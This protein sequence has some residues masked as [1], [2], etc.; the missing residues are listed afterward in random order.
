[1][2]PD[3]TW[4]SDVES[5]MR[6][7]VVLRGDLWRSARPAPVVIFRTPYGR[8]KISSDVLKPM[9][10][11]EFGFAAFVQDTRGRFGSEG[12]WKPIMWDQEALDT[13]DTVEWAAAQPWC[14]GTVILAGTSYGGILSMLGAATRPPHLAGVAAAMVTT[15][16]R[17]RV[18]LSGA[19][20]LDHL[21]GWMIFMAA[22]WL[23]RNPEHADAD[24]AALL[25]SLLADPVT[26]MRSLPLTA[27]PLAR[28]RGFPLD[29]E[30]LLS[31]SE[32]AL[33]EWEP[34]AIKVP[35]FV[36]TGWYDV[37]ASSTIDTF[38]A[39]AAANP[40]IPHRLVVGPW[41][42]TGPL[43]HIQGEVNFGVA[44]SATAVGLPGRQLDFFRRCAESAPVR[45][46]R[47]VDYFLMGADQWMSADQWPPS[48]VVSRP[49][50]L[51]SG[52]SA[53]VPG[54]LVSGR[55]PVGEDGTDTFVYDPLSPVPS[56]GGR[57]L[58]LGRLAPG[59]I[60][61]SRQCPRADTLHYLSAPLAEPVDV[62]GAVSMTLRVS[63]DRPDT[64]LFVRLV[65]R[66][67]DGRMLP[68]AD[69]IT[70]VRFRDD[71]TTPQPLAPGEIAT[72][73]IDMGYTA[74]R[75]D[76]GHRIGVLVTSSNF[77]HVDRNLNGAP[78]DADPPPVTVRIHAAGSS[79]TLDTLPSERTR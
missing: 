14:D 70:R 46:A 1:M 20:R 21:F 30:Q 73:A 36:S 44:A 75:F 24:N 15:G 26:A 45:P 7:G 41:A 69:G 28:L 17:D 13:H 65:D 79:L 2:N 29:V 49:F 58:H 68:V 61:L 78:A 32:G 22:D 51:V 16:S 12:E 23:A 10:C 66:Y 48:G 27:N 60:D 37:Y 11:V 35:V 4:H 6:D 64:D 31:G 9:D 71:L 59:P 8:R 56:R 5:P 25:G 50:R 43:Q 54:G 34:D 55:A 57:L 47:Q 52:A 67:P 63:L 77:P 40:E 62:V 38:T 33:P 3:A 19:L 53:G 74:Q 39:G 72:I 76:I 42:H 18:E